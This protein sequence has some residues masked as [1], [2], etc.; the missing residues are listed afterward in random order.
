M[1]FP[2]ILTNKIGKRKESEENITGIEMLRMNTRGGWAKMIK[3]CEEEEAGSFDFGSGIAR[4]RDDPDNDDRSYM[5]VD[6]LRHSEFCQLRIQ[7]I[8]WV[9]VK[10]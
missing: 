7:V 8:E 3:A 5:Y 10:I 1:I 2:K 9:Q 6:C 4:A